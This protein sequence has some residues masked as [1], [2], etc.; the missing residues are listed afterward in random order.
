M[1]SLSRAARALSTRAH[2]PFGKQDALRLRA[3]GTGANV[4]AA[5]NPGV[6]VEP[7]FFDEQ[8]ELALA[9][10][11]RALVDEC[12]YRLQG[13]TAT[14][15]I[16][17]DGSRA[18]TARR[19][20]NARVTGRYERP[21]QTCAAWGY[22]DNCQPDALPPAIRQLAERLQAHPSFALGKL[23]D[24]T[25]NA[26]T[27][28]FFQ[29]D[30]HVDPAA[31]GENVL[32][33]NLLSSAVLTFTPAQPPAGLER[34]TDAAVVGERSWT[35]ADVDCLLERRTVVHF[36]A[37]ARSRWMHAIRSGVLVDV[38]G[39]DKVAD[40]WGQIDYLIG[41]QPERISIVFAFA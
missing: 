26:R 38:D 16:G 25:I 40:W 10:E 18:S 30:P 9:A 13:E 22:G 6:R 7:A 8:F 41:R 31:D 23:R 11:A 24:V 34:R 12:G 35:D 32:I 17:A 37:A 3:V 29:L 5:A 1:A 36:C 33:A 14:L 27:D 4:R 15:A 19:A 20:N 39:E 21:E 28:A 2:R